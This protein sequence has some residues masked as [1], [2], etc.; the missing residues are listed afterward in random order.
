VL[1]WHYLLNETLRAEAEI[2]GGVVQGFRPKVGMMTLLPFTEA[3][4]VL[5]EGM[6]QRRPLHRTTLEHAARCVESLLDAAITDKIPSSAATDQGS[7]NQHAPAS[8]DEL[9]T[10]LSGL[11]LQDFEQ[12]LRDFGVGTPAD[13]SEKNK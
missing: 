13:L 12:K 2:V 11:E 3:I 5:F 6:L 7:D 4:E 8:M 10:L 1:F 9:A